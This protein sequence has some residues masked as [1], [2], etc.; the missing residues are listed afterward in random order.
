MLTTRGDIKEEQEDDDDEEEEEE[1]VGNGT[2]RAGLNGRASGESGSGVEAAVRG[3]ASRQGCS[4]LPQL[5]LLV[6]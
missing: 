3:A 2:A 1:D 5:L 4:R 6:S